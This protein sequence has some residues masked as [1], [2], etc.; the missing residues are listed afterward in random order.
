MLR[1]ITK[2]FFVETVAEIVGNKLEEETEENK[3]T[4]RRMNK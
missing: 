2:K 1:L 3:Q 4:K